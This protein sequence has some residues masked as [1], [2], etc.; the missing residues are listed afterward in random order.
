MGVGT[1]DTTLKHTDSHEGGIGGIDLENADDPTLVEHCLTGDQ[2]AWP[3]LVRRYG[4]LVEAVIR[5]Y[6]LSPDDHAD[7]FQDVWVELWRDLGS[8]RERDRLKPWLVTVAGRLAWDARKRLRPQTDGEAGEGLL[9]RVVDESADP[10]EDAA[11]KEMAEHIRLALDMVSPRCR[12]LISALFFEEAVPYTEIAARL[13]CAPNSIGP[14]RGR[15]FSELRD[16]LLT[17]RGE[18]QPGG[19]HG[20][21]HRGR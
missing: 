16:A 5:R 2:A 21:G 18:A 9:E 1:A 12:E 8:V 6:H 13:G 14:I 4:R 17:I 15:C 19:H 3:W 11:R 7:V 10:E 20:G